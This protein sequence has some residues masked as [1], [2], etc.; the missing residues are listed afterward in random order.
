[1]VRN[2]YVELSTSQKDGIAKDAFVE[3]LNN[4]DLELAVFQGR[5][6]SLQEAVS[7]AL[8]FEAF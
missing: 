4:Q 1:M 5:P 8:E 3:A 2:A 7:I 6:R